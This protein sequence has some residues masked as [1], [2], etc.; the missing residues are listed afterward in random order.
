MTGS[1]LFNAGPPSQ[2]AVGVADP[3]SRLAGQA[4][5]YR[6]VMASAPVQFGEDDRRDDHISLHERGGSHSGPDFL[7]PSGGATA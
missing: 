4:G 3:D 1:G 5:V 6:L 2:R 7:L